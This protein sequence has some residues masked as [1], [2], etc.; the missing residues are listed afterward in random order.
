MTRSTSVRS[1]CVSFLGTYGSK[2]VDEIAN[3]HI[4]TYIHA[5]KND[6]SVLPR[7]LTDVHNGQ[8]TAA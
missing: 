2:Y 1:S 3:K 5:S 8:V 4:H 6:E 7:R